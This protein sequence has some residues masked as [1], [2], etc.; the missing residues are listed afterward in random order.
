MVWGSI[1]DHDRSDLIILQR[2]ISS[3]RQ[4]YTAPSYIAALELGL[5]SIWQPDRIYQQD[6]APIHT[7]NKTKK[8]FEE[9]GLRLLDDWPPYSPDL[10]PIEH[11]WALLKQKLY[12][13]YPD[14]E[15]WS[16]N[17]EEMQERMEDALVHAWGQLDS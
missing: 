6:N 5:P 11:I 4:G 17:T 12:E 7:A 15:T 2:D 16:G 9:I 1:C 8:Y 3:K 14:C 10:N 13:L